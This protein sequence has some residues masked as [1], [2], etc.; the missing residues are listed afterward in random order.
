MGRVR[1]RQK[2]L[3]RICSDAVRLRK[4][5][6]VLRIPIEVGSRTS[7]FRNAASTSNCGWVVTLRRHLHGRRDLSCERLSS[8][9]RSTFFAPLC[10]HILEFLLQEFLRNHSDLD[11]EIYRQQNPPPTTRGLLC[12][13]RDQSHGTHSTISTSGS[14][15]STGYVNKNSYM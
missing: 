12:R 9:L 4:S 15:R 10:H 14:A 5:I 7:G 8:D 1:Y 13:C 11:L 3:A 2:K 6:W